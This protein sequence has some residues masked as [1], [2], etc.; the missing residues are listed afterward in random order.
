MNNNF[1]TLFLNV[2]SYFG[3]TSNIQTIHCNTRLFVPIIAITPFEQVLAVPDLEFLVRLHRQRGRQ[4]IKKQLWR[5]GCG[6][7][8]A[9]KLA[10]PII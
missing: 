6:P 10:V 3:D 8:Q 2:L 1:G 9:V 7:R 4:I 5:F